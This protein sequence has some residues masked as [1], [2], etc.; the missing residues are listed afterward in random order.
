MLSHG[1]FRDFGQKGAHGTEF[2]TIAGS[3]FT[4]CFE[5]RGY[6]AR[7]VAAAD[8]NDST[9]NSDVNAPRAFLS[10]VSASLTKGARGSIYRAHGG[11]SKFCISHA[12]GSTSFYISCRYFSDRARR[13][14]MNNCELVLKKKSRSIV[15]R[16]GNLKSC[17]INVRCLNVENNYKHMLNL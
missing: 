7:V 15:F 5:E 1:D 3:C 16:N 17:Y 13:C 6:I 11:K 4:G 9:W 10:R 14:M 8:A 2:W 12:I